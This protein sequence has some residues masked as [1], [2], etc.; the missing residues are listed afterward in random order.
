MNFSTFGLSL[1]CRH[2]L[3]D[4]FIQE[5][6]RVA[7]GDNGFGLVVGDFDAELF[8]EGHHQFNGIERIG[9]EVVDE[10]GAVDDLVGF[11]AEMLND[12]LFYALRDI[13]HFFFSL[14][15]R[16]LPPGLC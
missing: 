2:F 14:M 4:A 12:D 3:A 8:L 6:H 1:L 5:L 10:I 9:A 13:A 15:R 7:D 11:H 16:A